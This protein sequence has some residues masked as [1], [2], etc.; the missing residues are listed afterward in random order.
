MKRMIIAIAITVALLSLAL[1]SGTRRVAGQGEP[2]T[3]ENFYRAENPVGGRYYVILRN[4]I[5]GAALEAVAEELAA[6]HNTIVLRY[7]YETSLNGFE[8]EMKEAAAFAV[9]AD[10]RVEFV[11]EVDEMKPAIDE[12]KPLAK[13]EF[14]EVDN[15]P[16]EEEIVG[17][18]GSQGDT[19]D[20]RPEPS[21]EWSTDGDAVAAAIHQPGYILRLASDPRYFSYENQ[22][23][24]LVGMSGSYLPHVARKRPTTWGTNGK[25]LYYDPVFENCTYD[26]VGGNLPGTTTP[27]RKYH[28][29]INQLRDA[30]MNHTQIW[31]ALNHSVGKLIKEGPNPRG[32]VQGAP[33]PNEQPF[34]W[35]GTKWDLNTF[36]NTFFSN[37][38]EV[39]K[40]CQEQGIVVGVVLF[41][42][43]SGWVE[44]FNEPR[45]SPW[46]PANNTS[47]IGFTSPKQFVRPDVANLNTAGVPDSPIDSATGNNRALRNIQVA[48]MKRTA[49]ELKDLKNFYWVLANEPDFHGEDN[50]IGQPLVTWLRFMARSLKKYED[51]LPGKPHHLI[52][53]N[54]TTNPVNIAGYPAPNPNPPPGTTNQVI[55]A[56]AH[57]DSVDIIT[58]HYVS[59]NKDVPKVNRDFRLGAMELLRVYNTYNNGAP[60][61]HNTKRWGFSEDNTSGVAT[62][63]PV[64]SFTWTDFDDAYTAAHVRVEAWEFLMNGG[65]VFDHLSYR[66]GNVASTTGTTDYNSG[67]NAQAILA[68][69]QLGYLGNFL[70]TI[71]L[72]KMTRTMENASNRWLD[73][74][75]YGSQSY[76]A[77]MSRPSESPL[78]KQQFLFYFHRSAS[79]DYGVRYEVSHGGGTNPKVSLNVKNLAGG[80][81]A[82]RGC[83]RADWYYPSGKTPSGGSAQT[84]GVLN[85]VR[86]DKIEFSTL[87]TISALQSPPYVQDILLKI[88]RVQSGACPAVLP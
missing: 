74:P 61:G 17:F 22:T 4:D 15:K 32:N 82:E 55:D 18:S 85:I 64:N 56:M 51:E 71:N 65:A 72:D 43:W 49:L 88:T 83:Y 11:A 45:I 50:A 77:A 35:N 67:H 39:V 25:N 23:I 20:T 75:T 46:W 60:E 62:W 40:Y 81:N 5:R 9:C 38:K 30:G 57:T 2:T 58:S 53:V 59:L 1:S 21:P 27:M 66:W 13:E 68:R 6:A 10:A 7:F 42:P 48:L 69:D 86:S 24:S 36:D 73:A 16:V 26:T 47:G 19:T 37:L 52:A 31:V 3:P 14:P 80:I 63:Y 87:G 29:C 34:A 84:S 54:A 76:W 79:V 12:S 8:I 33:Y 28:V 44:A 70:K 41:D 78:H